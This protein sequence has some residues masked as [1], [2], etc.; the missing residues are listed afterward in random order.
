MENLGTITFCA[1]IQKNSLKF[2]Y[3]HR[4]RTQVSCIAGQI[5]YQL[6]HQGNHVITHVIIA[7]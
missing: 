6:S 1:S 4:D 5:L 3:Q 2:R 7:P